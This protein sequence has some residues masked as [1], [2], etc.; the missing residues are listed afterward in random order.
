V[1]I[2][3]GN[4]DQTIEVIRLRNGELI[5]DID[6]NH[7]SGKIYAAGEY[8]YYFPND[9]AA[10][11]M[12]EEPIQYEDDVVYII[13]DKNYSDTGY[14]VLNQALSNDG[15]KRIKL[16]GEV[17]EG[18]EGDMSS[19]AVDTHTDKIYA[20]IRYF[21]G[22]RTGVFIIDGSSNIYT[23]NTIKFLPL[24]ETGPDQIL[25]NNKTNTIYASFKDDD[26]VSLIN[27]SNNR[28]IEKIILQQPKAM[29]INPR[30]GLLYVAGGD[31]FWFNVIN[32]NTTKVIA[33]NTEINYPI[34][35][36]VTGTTM[37]GRIYVADCLQCG[38]YN[39]AH[40]TSIYE[41]DNNGST[42]NWRTFN[43]INI[44]ENE[45]AINPY[46]NKLYAIGTD[47]QSGKSNLYVINISSQ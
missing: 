31:G 27:G 44:E 19:I 14:N 38:H 34:A 46:T 18:K 21:E 7:F 2:L 40:G 25:V 9:I 12:N 32:M 39:F 35:S 33:S 42:L 23:P 28:E 36:A 22:G 15:I 3:D 8:N 10:D 20:G 41:L 4:T 17:E 47:I 11:E 43:D 1:Y 24:G 45:L 16:Y 13:D 6:I 37:T 30:D 29:S 5:H 26:F